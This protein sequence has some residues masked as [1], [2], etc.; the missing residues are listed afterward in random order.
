MHGAENE[1]SN[2]I[3]Y[4]LPMLDIFQPVVALTLS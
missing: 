1:D 4:F 3:F 2:S